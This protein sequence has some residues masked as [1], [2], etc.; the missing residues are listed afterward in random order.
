MKE[1]PPRPTKTRIKGV[2]NTAPPWEPVEC[3]VPDLAAIHA[4][5]RGEADRDQQIRFVEWLARATGVSESEFRLDDRAHVF[6][7]GKRFV[8]LQF[9]SLAK[10]YIP[11]DDS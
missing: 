7:S 8:G 1:Q 6:A 10:S 4:L 2:A 5:T 9:F 3:D 11:R